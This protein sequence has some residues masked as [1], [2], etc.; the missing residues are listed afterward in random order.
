MRERRQYTELPDV[1]LSPELDEQIR[2]MT[3]QADRDIAERRSAES[4]AREITPRP[5]G[6]TAARSP[7]RR[8]A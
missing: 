2:A 8:Q 4:S 6:Q 1:E 5:D 3:E 7:R